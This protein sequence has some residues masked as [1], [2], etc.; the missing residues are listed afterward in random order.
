MA[1][2][3]SQE[4]YRSSSGRRRAIPNPGR[5]GLHGKGFLWGQRPGRISRLDLRKHIGWVD[6]D[7]VNAI[8]AT[9]HVSPDVVARLRQAT[10]ER[11]EHG[12]WQCGA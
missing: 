1:G 3:T 11:H 7:L 5:C 6:E 9:M 2:L 10:R 4:F 12:T 8:A